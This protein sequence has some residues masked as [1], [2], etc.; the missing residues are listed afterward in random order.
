[1][2]EVNTITNSLSGAPYAHISQKAKMVIDSDCGELICRG[3]IY[4]E[5]DFK[6][7]RFKDLKWKFLVSF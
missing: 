3:S 1:M 2:L 4:L 5:E 7:V 6:C